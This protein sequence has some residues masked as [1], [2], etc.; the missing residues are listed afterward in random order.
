MAYKN[1]RVSVGLI[2]LFL[3][4]L[5]T[6]GRAMQRCSL[7]TDRAAM[8][9]QHQKHDGCSSDEATSQKAIDWMGRGRGRTIRRQPRQHDWARTTGDDKL[10]SP[11]IAGGFKRGF[12]NG[13]FSFSFVNEAVIE[14]EA[15]HIHG[16]AAQS[17][18]FKSS[19]ESQQKNKKKS[20]I[21]NSQSLAA[22]IPMT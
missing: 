19:N 12:K 4:L 2:P 20:E 6:F 17:L 18:C 13:R 9:E 8:Q 16:K 21:A 11:F 14:K 1:S 7:T 10:Q 22:P 3:S 5:L 15:R